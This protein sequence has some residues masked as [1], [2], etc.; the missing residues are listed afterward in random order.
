MAEEAVTETEATSEVTTEALATEALGADTP[1]AAAETDATAEVKADAGKDAEVDA[2][3]AGDK[4]DGDAP[5]DFATLKLPEGYKTDDPVFADF[6]K[7]AGD[8]KLSP[9][10]AQKLVDFTVT[11]D[12]ALAKAVA[13]LNVEAWKKTGD[14]WKATTAKENTPEQLSDAKTAL[15]KWFDKDTVALFE[16][17]R[18]TD[19]PG[20]VKGLRAIGAA[21]KDDT[22]VPGNAGSRNGSGDARKSFPNSNMN[23]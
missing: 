23:P 11:R 3:K 15:G 8:E 14:A 18:F 9:A 5:S 7:L 4:K 21:I 12:Q 16:S 20:L 1:K 17:M 10:Q 22:F 6:V 13:D 19:H 2:G